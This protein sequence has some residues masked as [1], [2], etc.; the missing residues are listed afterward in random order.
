MCEE[1]RLDLNV[2]ICEEFVEI[3]TEEQDEKKFNSDSEPD[4]DECTE[5]GREFI[6]PMEGNNK[7]SAG[8]CNAH[9]ICQKCMNC[10]RRAIKSDDGVSNVGPCEDDE[11]YYKHWNCNVRGEEITLT[12]INENFYALENGEKVKV[13]PN[14]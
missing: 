12:Y 14:A 1:N 9:Y 7:Y 2:E 6:Y 13:Y 3:I 4:S 8:P 5:C 10:G 11:D